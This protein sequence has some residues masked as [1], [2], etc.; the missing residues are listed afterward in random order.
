MVGLTASTSEPL[1]EWIDRELHDAWAAQWTGAL[2]TAAE[3]GKGE[4]RRQLSAAFPGTRAPFLITASVYPQRSVSLGA[5]LALE[6]RGPKAGVILEAWSST[7]TIRGQGGQWLAIPA[8]ACPRKANG[9]RMTPVEVEAF[10][11]AE[12]Q[13]VPKRGTRTGVLVLDLV[14]ARSGR[15]HRAATARRLAAGRQALPTILFVVTPQATLHRRL[16][17]DAA[18]GASVTSVGNGRT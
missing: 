2:R 4:F 14:A 18:V 7:T 10:Y 1:A 15:G 3:V 5:V 9:T 11:N 13:F 6:A 12:L 8:P 17:P 16:D